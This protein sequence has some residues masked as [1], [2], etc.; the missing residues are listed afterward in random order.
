MQIQKFIP[1]GIQLSPFLNT[2]FDS[3][4]DPYIER[5]YELDSSIVTQ[6]ILSSMDALIETMQTLTKFSAER[7]LANY[8]VSLPSPKK[9][10]ILVCIRGAY[11][12]DGS[13]TQK[14]PFFPSDKRYYH[15]FTYVLTTFL[16]FE[17]HCKKQNLDLWD[18]ILS[19]EVNL[20]YPPTN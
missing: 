9:F 1:I 14:I 4:Q 7:E 3:Q 11:A 18:E 10:L 8:V 15:A 19:Y 2:Y 16:E 13:A 17:T 12:Y 20:L 6:T 5:Q